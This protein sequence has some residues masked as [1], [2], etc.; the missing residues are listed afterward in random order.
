M[1]ELIFKVVVSTADEDFFHGI[2]RCVMKNIVVILR[3]FIVPLQSVTVKEA[4]HERRNGVDKS[5][6]VSRY[7]CNVFFILS[8]LTL[9]STSVVTHDVLVSAKL[10]RDY[11]NYEMEVE[12]ADC[13]LI[14][15]SLD[16]V[17]ADRGA[18]LFHAGY[19]SCIICSGGSSSRKHLLGERL[20]VSE[21]ENLSK[22]LMDLGV[23]EDAVVLET[24]SSN[25]MENISFSYELMVK[26]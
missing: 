24:L 13:I 11:L 12:K 26:L 23:P 8:I 3:H 22:R 5:V 21:A 25:T 1:F 4:V 16:L 14:F 7:F 19:A 2:E 9:M 6:F 18:E 15:G 10:L 20:S 17:A